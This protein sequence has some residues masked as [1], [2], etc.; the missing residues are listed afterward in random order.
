MIHCHLGLYKLENAIRH[1][2][3]C[4]PNLF[5]AHLITVKI[6]QLQIYCFHIFGIAICD[7]L[8]S[9]GI[10]RW[11]A[12]GGEWIDKRT[13]VLKLN[14][15]KLVD[16]ERVNSLTSVDGK[17]YLNAFLST[18]RRSYLT[19]RVTILVMKPSGILLDHCERQL[20]PNFE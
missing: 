4:T 1:L 15:G 20:R 13:A 3:E 19:R 7:A 8:C 17:F 11:C 6:E 5:M 10:H 12:K 2:H 16:D 18:V 14:G 9:A